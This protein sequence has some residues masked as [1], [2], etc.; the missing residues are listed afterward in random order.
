[1]RPVTLT[2]KILL[3][4]AMAILLW[5]QSRQVLF[6]ARSQNA[7]RNAA[8][9]GEL[10]VESSVTPSSA[11]LAKRRGDHLLLKTQPA[12]LDG[13]IREYRHAVELDPNNSEYW[14]DLGKAL[15]QAERVQDAAGPFAVADQLDPKNH[16]I[17]Q[18]IGNYHLAQ[19]DIAQAMEHHARA[20]QQ[21]P[22]VARGIYVLYWN[23]GQ[24]LTNIADALLGEDLALKQRYF[25]DALVSAEPNE[26]E[27]LWSLLEQ[28]DEALDAD[29]HRA[30]FSYLLTNRCPDAAR[31]LWRTIAQDF[32]DTHWDES[33]EIF[34]N[35]DFERPIQFQ[36]GLEWLEKPAPEGMT[37]TLGAP[38]AG[39]NSRAIHLAF[40]G[41][42][43]VAYSGISHAFFVEPGKSYA[44]RYRV[45]AK[46]ITTHN[47][48]YIRLTLHA[49]KPVVMRSAPAVATMDDEQTI[50]FSVPDDAFWGE[51]H[52]CRDFSRKLNNKIKGEAW[53]SRFK[54]E[55]ITGLTNAE[56]H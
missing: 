37:A 38:V 55:E 12:D 28:T 29:C 26:V 20:I 31:Q 56:I 11:A 54:L 53:F 25:Q 24:S 6:D 22:S 19:R 44:L 8:S 43:N 27:A 18:A 23:L 39:S 35:R 32:Y 51:I 15:V 5:G 52:L 14:L 2:L 46:D 7:L 50:E 17:Q 41:T 36:G 47:G 9:Y 34:W 40:D 4:V 45:R 48:P 21:Y 3:L 16:H 42:H 33:A 13:A 30:Y 49:E 1:M 10:N